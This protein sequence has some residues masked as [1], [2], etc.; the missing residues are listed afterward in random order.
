MKM[1]EAAISPLVAKSNQNVRK[2]SQLEN[3]SD[4]NK[5]QDLT[6]KKLAKSSEISDN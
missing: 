3:I 1:L 4:S 6:G 5:T 2:T